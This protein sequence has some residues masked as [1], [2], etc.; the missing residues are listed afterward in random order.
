M[1]FGIQCGL[2]DVP[3]GYAAVSH[4]LCFINYATQCQHGF[5]YADYYDYPECD[6]WIE[7]RIQDLRVA[8]RTT[9]IPELNALKTRCDLKIALFERRSAGK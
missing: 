6:G 5:K 8:N 7:N 9:F 2:K 4:S 1:A 3:G